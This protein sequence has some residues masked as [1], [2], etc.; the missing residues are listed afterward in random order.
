MQRRPDGASGARTEH[1]ALARCEYRLL[2][3]KETAGDPSAAVP[4]GSDDSTKYTTGTGGTDRRGTGT[5]EWNEQRALLARGHPEDK[6]EQQG[7]PERQRALIACSHQEGEGGGPP[8]QQ[9]E[10][11]ARS[12]GMEGDTLTRKRAPPACIQGT[13]EGGGT[14]TQQRTLPAHS[15]GV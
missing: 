14:P 1:S 9:R 12:Q 6:E 3:S 2:P 15:Q 7:P 10:L 11:P 13:E 8:I 5:W 4:Q